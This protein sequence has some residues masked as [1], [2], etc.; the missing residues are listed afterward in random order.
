M[1]PVFHSEDLPVSHPGTHVT[2][3]NKV[4]DETTTESRNE[5]TRRPYF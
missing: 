4:E 1:S 2:L 3:T 5:H